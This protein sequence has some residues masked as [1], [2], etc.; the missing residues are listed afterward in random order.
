MVKVLEGIIGEI[1]SISG[2]C[3]QNNYTYTHAPQSYKCTYPT[4]IKQCTIACY[5]LYIQLSY[6]HVYCILSKTSIPL[7]GQIK[8]KTGLYGKCYASMLRYVEGS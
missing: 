5:S 7:R 8:G 2:S 4:N 1:M 6:D 3:L